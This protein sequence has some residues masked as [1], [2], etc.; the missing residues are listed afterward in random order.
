MD[1]ADHG[2]AAEWPEWKRSLLASCTAAIE[3]LPDEPPAS[4]SLRPG[5]QSPSLYSFFEEIAV[6]RNEMRKGNRR[7]AE[8]FAKFGEILENMREDSGKLR[9][10]LANP[11]SADSSRGAPRKFALNLV[12]FI[13]RTARL[14]S[15]ARTQ[16]G[17]GWLARLRSGDA[18][19]QQAEALSILHEHLHHLVS[20]SGLERIEASPGTPFDPL[21]M[22]S[23]GRTAPRKGDGAAMVVSE[24][25]LP[26]YR[27]GEQCLRP[28]EVRVTNTTS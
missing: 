28:A 6:L 10:R 25:L 1:T 18:W 13:D 11:A 7:T 2:E 21:L 5:E 20:E 17:Q 12:E 14:E 24:Q 3:S 9:E 26:G 4:T 16:A 22:K 15:S 27:L 8:T 23:V 19:V